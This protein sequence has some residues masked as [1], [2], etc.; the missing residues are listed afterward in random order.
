MEFHMGKQQSL[1][2]HPASYT[3]SL[4]APEKLMETIWAERPG[5]GY[6]RRRDLWI[7]K[8]C[9]VEEIQAQ[10]Y[11]RKK[12]VDG[13]EV[14]VCPHCGMYVCSIPGALL[15]KHLSECKGGHEDWKILEDAIIQDQRRRNFE[16]GI[17]AARLREQE[18]QEHTE[19]RERFD[20]IREEQVA[21]Q[22]A[23]DRK[24]RIRRETREEFKRR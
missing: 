17:M 10:G 6:I 12:P 4:D 20:R 5:W 8:V 3:F 18:E 2:L 21:R 19:K 9:S 16:A 7:E 24:K 22:D 11:V 15:G 14:K 13:E 1:W 23:K